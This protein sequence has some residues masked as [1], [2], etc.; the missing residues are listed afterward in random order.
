M[1]ADL[2]VFFCMLCLMGVVIWSGSIGI[3]TSGN[4]P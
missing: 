2:A 4:S 3:P 1:A